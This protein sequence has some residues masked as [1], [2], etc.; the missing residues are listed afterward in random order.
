MK[1]FTSQGVAVVPSRWIRAMEPG[2][3]RIQAHVFVYAESKADVAALLV[4][5][6]LSEQAAAD[7]ARQLKLNRSSA[8]GRVRELV[9]A[10][11]VDPGQR[12][13]YGYREGNQNDPVVRLDADLPVVAHFRYRD[14]T[15][16]VSTG[17]PVGLYAEPVKSDD[18]TRITMQTQAPIEHIQVATTNRPLGWILD[19]GRGDRRRELEMDQPYQRGD[20][21]GLTRRRNLIR[22]M[23]LGIPIPSLVVNDRF[24]A[25][26]REPGYEQDRN[27]AYAIVDGKQR[28][29]T[30]LMFAN[31]EFAVPASWFAADEIEQTEDTADG[32]YVRYS[33]ISRRM[34]RHFETLPIGVAEGRFKTLAA[35]RMVFELV[36]FGG[37]PQGQ[38]DDDLALP[39]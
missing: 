28:A 20:V 6:G 39:E 27:W 7:V 16:A 37:V 19:F 5:G 36:N 32:P 26:F 31:D 2:S 17:L 18:S 24:G 8:P 22:S 33:G 29:T 3:T 23:L 15:E 14:N 34:Q 13:A 21:W 11:V 9:E 1:L 30:W 35:E 4:E 10:G 12:G 38:T 25:R